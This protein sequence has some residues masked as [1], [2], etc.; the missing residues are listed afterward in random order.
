MA[1]LRGKAREA[2][3]QKLQTQYKKLASTANRRLSNIEK[4]ADDP[5]F[6]TA[7][8]GYAYKNALYDIQGLPGG[9]GKVRYPMDISRFS[10]KKTNI[11]DLRQAI[12][13][14]QN[15][16]DMPSSTKRGIK[17]VYGKRAKTLNKKYNTDL[18]W[19]DLREFFEST[20]WKKMNTKYGSK[21]ALKAIAKVQ[22]NSGDVLKDIQS[23]NA[24]NKRINIKSLENIDGYNLNKN[25]N[26]D[27][28]KV[29]ENLARIYKDRTS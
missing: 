25:M 12:V 13:S 27:D 20:F 18:T 22:K 11:R 17:K 21:T 5:D 1:K 9:E 6:G 10:A 14:V 19:Q 16:L 8:L 26:K 7:V 3:I 2:E 28:L 4:L 15:F 23:A 24:E 29:I